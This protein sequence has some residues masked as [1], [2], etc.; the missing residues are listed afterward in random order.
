[1]KQNIQFSQLDMACI[2]AKMYFELLTQFIFHIEMDLLD[3]NYDQQEFEEIK[4][5]LDS[6]ATSLESLVEIDVID[7]FGREQG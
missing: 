7:N 2:R 4:F 6:I 5:A 3:Y 1:M